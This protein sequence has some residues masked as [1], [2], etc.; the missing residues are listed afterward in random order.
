MISKRL[1]DETKNSSIF[2]VLNI[3]LP[4]YHLLFIYG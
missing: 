3:V 4:V 2:N 1:N